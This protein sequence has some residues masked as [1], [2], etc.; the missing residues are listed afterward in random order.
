MNL[1]DPST[2]LPHVSL[3]FGTMGRLQNQVKQILG[4]SRDEHH[5]RDV[6]LAM[7]HAGFPRPGRDLTCQQFTLAA[8]PMCL[9]VSSLYHNSAYH[10]LF[11]L[12]DHRTRQ[13]LGKA[14]AFGGLELVLFSPGELADTVRLELESDDVKAIRKALE[15]HF[16]VEEHQDQWKLRVGQLADRLPAEFGRMNPA[17]AKCLR[18][19]V[20]VVLGAPD[21]HFSSMRGALKAALA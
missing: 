5:E 21:L 8:E 15:G 10:F 6:A 14:L 9:V 11:R 12:D 2:P 13:A 17:A 19:Y 18:H 4:C 1:K 16:S 20:L 7:S 3:N